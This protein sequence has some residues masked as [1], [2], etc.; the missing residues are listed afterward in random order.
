VGGFTVTKLD[1]IE[2]LDD[3]RTPLKPVRHRLGITAFGVNAWTA[4]AAG[5]RMIPEHDQENDDEEL[6]LVQRGRATFELDGERVDA[7]A[8]TLVFVQ[9]AVR[10]TAFAEEAETTI[11]AVG[12]TPG[13]AFQPAGWEI[14]FPFRQLY[15]SGMYAE[16]A[17]RGRELIETQP[18]YAEPV[19]NLACCEALAGRPADAIEH[20]RRA[21]ELHEPLR[22][23]AQTDSDLDPIRDEPSFKEL[24]G[25]KQ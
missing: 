22:E 13:E 9:P 18:P 14:W 10:R 12:A 2:P 17:D 24:I 7:P 15:E 21:I 25:R 4:A 6:Y 11:L 20:L 3:G 1:E 8:G 19:Y 16:I 23:L 5:D